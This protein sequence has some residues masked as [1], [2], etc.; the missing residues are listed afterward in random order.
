M[1]PELLAIIKAFSNL[2]IAEIFKPNKRFWF[3][4]Q[5][6]QDTSN[7]FV[8]LQVVKIF[9]TVPIL[10]FRKIF[11]QCNFK[12]NEHGIFKRYVLV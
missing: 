1:F 11:L 3:P 6:F 8:Y 12:L 7:Y 5:V 10:L 2:I 9:Y 4:I